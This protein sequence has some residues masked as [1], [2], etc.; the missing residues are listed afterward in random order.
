MKSVE[1]VARVGQKS[2]IYRIRVRKSEGT[3]HLEDVSLEENMILKCILRS[4][5]VGYGVGPAS[6]GWGPVTG[7]CRNTKKICTP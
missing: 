1:H 2:N 4:G 6:S 7:S 5:I 3:C